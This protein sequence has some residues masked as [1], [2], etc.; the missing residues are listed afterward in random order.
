MMHEGPCDLGRMVPTSGFGP[1]LHASSSLI[2]PKDPENLALLL[3]CFILPAQLLL[4]D[5]QDA[6]H[7]QQLAL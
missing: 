2:Q 3:S 7:T 4:L 5:L 1:S 6:L